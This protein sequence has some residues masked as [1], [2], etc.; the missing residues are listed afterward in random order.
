M[1][2]VSGLGGGRSQLGERPGLDAG[3]GDGASER[4]GAVGFSG[5]GDRGGE[6]G[7]R[8]CLAAG[9][10]SAQQTVGSAVPGRL[11]YVDVADITPQLSAHLRLSTTV[12]WRRRLSC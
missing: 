10:G 12:G 5:L 3:A 9:I 7:K 8:P 4:L 6:L 2:G 1:V 11:A